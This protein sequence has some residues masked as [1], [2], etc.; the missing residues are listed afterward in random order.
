MI[1]MMI[2]LYDNCDDFDN[3]DDDDD[4]EILCY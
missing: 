2:A 1:V 3:D 4:D